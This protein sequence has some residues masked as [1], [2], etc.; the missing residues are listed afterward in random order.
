MTREFLYTNFG[1][2]IE[3]TGMTRREAAF[4]VAKALE[5]SESNVRF[6]GGCYDKYI[7]TDQINRKWNIVSDSSIV[8]ERKSRA[9]SLY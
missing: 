4:V 5:V 6:A 1:I 3:F 8:A 2:E 7:V 9:G